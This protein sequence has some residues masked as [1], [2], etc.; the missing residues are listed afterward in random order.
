MKCTQCQ[1]NKPPTKLFYISVKS[2]PFNDPI[3]EIGWTRVN[4][5]VYCDECKPNEEAM[6]RKNG[7]VEIK[8]IC[9]AKTMTEG[10]PRRKR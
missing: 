9:V 3:D 6:E 5:S 4:D 8:W 10:D 1:K 7:A 2:N